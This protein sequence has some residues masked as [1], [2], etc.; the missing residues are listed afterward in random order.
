MKPAVFY[1]NKS[2]RQYESEAAADAVKEAAASAKA[3]DWQGATDPQGVVLLSSWLEYA[4]T[5]IYMY[6]CEA[7]WICMI[8]M[9]SQHVS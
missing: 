4:V 7:L 3:G 1:K 9:H 2:L 8:E 5:H 6:T